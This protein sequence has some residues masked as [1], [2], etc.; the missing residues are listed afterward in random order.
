MRDA[1]V[2]IFEILPIQLTI[3]H[4]VIIFMGGGVRHV[5]LKRSMLLCLPKR[6]GYILFIRWIFLWL[7][8]PGIG[9]YIVTKTNRV[10]STTQ[11][12]PNILV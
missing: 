7:P 3:I 2:P 11:S 1:G 8:M 6:V 9:I 5:L 12:H 10:T 4:I